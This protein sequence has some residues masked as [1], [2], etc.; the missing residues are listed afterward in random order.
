MKEKP[1]TEVNQ[2]VKDKWTVTH[3]YRGHLGALSAMQGGR[4]GEGLDCRVSW[5]RMT[6]V[7]GQGQ[8]LPL[9]EALKSN[10]H[11]WGESGPCPSGP[12]SFINILFDWG[13]TKWGSGQSQGL[14]ERH[15]HWIQ[16]HWRLLCLDIKHQDGDFVQGSLWRKIPLKGSGRKARGRNR[17][18]SWGWVSSVLTTF[19]ER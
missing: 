15:Y 1:R 9:R 6:D 8:A 17:S 10:L 16:A 7:R 3:E 2:P 5:I 4:Q 18:L 12:L 14:G 13:K 19:Q 11:K